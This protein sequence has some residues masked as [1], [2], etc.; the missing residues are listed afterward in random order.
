MDKIVSERYL[1][2][3]GWKKDACGWWISP[4]GY[5]LN[6]A[7]ELHKNASESTARAME[8][9]CPDLIP[10]WLNQER[11]INVTNTKNWINAFKMP[12]GTIHLVCGLC[13]AVDKALTNPDSTCTHGQNL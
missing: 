3:S 13:M 8:K 1:L 2:N 7:I 6:E 4:F 5:G 11:K 9:E 10:R 12:D